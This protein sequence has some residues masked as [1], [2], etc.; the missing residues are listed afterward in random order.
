MILSRAPRACSWVKGNL[1]KRL[2]RSESRLV[3]RAA[4]ASSVDSMPNWNPMRGPS[5]FKG[6]A[7]FKHS[8]T[9]TVPI[10]FSTISGR[11]I[12]ALN[13][14]TMYRSAAPFGVLSNNSERHTL[15]SRTTQNASMSGA[16]CRAKTLF[17]PD[18]STD[19]RLSVRESTCQLLRLEIRVGSNGSKPDGPRSSLGYRGN[20]YRGRQ[21]RYG[22]EIVAFFGIDRTRKPDPACSSQHKTGCA[23]C[24]RVAGERSG[25][26]ACEPSI[27]TDPPSVTVPAGQSAAWL[28]R[29]HRHSQR[30]RRPR[31]C[32]CTQPDWH[33][34]SALC[35]TDPGRQKRTT[36][37]P[38]G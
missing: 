7:A 18:R 31:P 21:G 5:T 16:L 14:F 37:R 4:K 27:R 23:V 1:L 17:W 38:S 11:P 8:M 26:T 35:R 6:F 30:E 24:A 12:L 29:S 13:R 2:A 22:V 36:R 34:R 9:I 25:T 33:L 28:G 15:V 32:P 19:W 3:T 20:R 10:S